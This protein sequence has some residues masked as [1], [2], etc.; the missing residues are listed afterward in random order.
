MTSVYTIGERF[1]ALIE[2]FQQGV[3]YNKYKKVSYRDWLTLCDL[4]D[5]GVKPIVI[6]FVDCTQITITAEDIVKAVDP[7]DESFGTFLFDKIFKNTNNIEEN[8]DNTEENETMDTNKMIKFDFGPCTHDNIRMSIYGLAV[9][10]AAGTYVSYNAADGSIM[11]VDIFNFDGGK[12]FYKM[13][14]AI[15]DIQA[16]DIVI[17]NRKPMFVIEILVETKGLKVVD[18]FNGERKEI[19]LSRSPFGFDFATKVVNL[20]G[21]LGAMGGEASADNPFGNMAMMMLMCGNDEETSMNDI[22]PFMLMS[23]GQINPLMAMMLCGGN[24]K[25]NMLPLMFAMNPN[26]LNPKQ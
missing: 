3:K 25:D 8:I 23:Q 22:L 20:I 12:F 9:K 6:K 19:M 1:K 2:D 10:N 14:V 26:L 24:N 11:D 21:N 15:K 5:L 16:G 13:P 4:G 17:H 7:T 18:P